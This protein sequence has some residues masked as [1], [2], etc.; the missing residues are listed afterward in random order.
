MEGLRVVGAE[1]AM[2]TRAIVKLTTYIP[3]RICLQ[4]D[5]H[6][7]KSRIRFTSPRSPLPPPPLPLI[8]HLSPAPASSYR[9][10]D[11]RFS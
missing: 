9:R 7:W 10:R 8:P 4:I 11:R 2:Q 5:L 1:S 3:A 6:A